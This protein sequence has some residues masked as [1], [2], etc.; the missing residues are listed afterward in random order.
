MNKLKPLQEPDYEILFRASVVAYQIAYNDY[1][2]A[3]NDYL[4]YTIINDD[5]M[6]CTYAGTEKRAERLKEAADRMEKAKI[7]VE[8]YRERNKDEADN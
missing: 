5:G 8:Y 7:D 2:K 1:K 3:V 6:F 4:E